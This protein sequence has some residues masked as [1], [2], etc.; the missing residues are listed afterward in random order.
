LQLVANP[1]YNSKQNRLWLGY[2]R[3][4]VVTTGENPS[5]RDCL[6]IQSLCLGESSSSVDSGTVCVYPP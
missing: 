4:K 1:N 5:T 3:T 2:C 6:C